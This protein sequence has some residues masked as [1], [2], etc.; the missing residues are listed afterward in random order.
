VPHS[1]PPFGRHLKNRSRTQK[2]LM[3]IAAVSYFAAIGCGVGAYV[4]DT[5]FDSPVIASMM[6]SVVFFTCV[7]A[8][9][10]VI[11]ST[12]LPNLKIHH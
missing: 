1:G 6:A 8:V 11:G 2:V 5:K 10:Q 7:G 3:V 12:N 4:L 9:L